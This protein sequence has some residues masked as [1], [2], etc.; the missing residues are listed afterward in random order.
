MG[1]VGGIERWNRSKVVFSSR[2]L[3]LV[4]A[5]LQ[6]AYAT[7]LAAVGAGHLLG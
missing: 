6:L 5:A 4:G 1:E 7:R 3:I 2:S